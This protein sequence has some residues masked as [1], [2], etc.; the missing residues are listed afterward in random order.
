[1]KG[2]SCGGD[3]GVSRARKLVNGQSSGMATR[4]RKWKSERRQRKDNRIDVMR[5]WEC[6]IIAGAAAR[7]TPEIGKQDAAYLAAW[8]SACTSAIHFRDACIITKVP[9]VGLPIFAR[10]HLYMISYYCFSLPVNFLHIR[11][12]QFLSIF[13]HTSHRMTLTMYACNTFPAGRDAQCVRTRIG[14]HARI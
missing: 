11:V 14:G 7:K 1:M 9:I 10:V 4:Y 6:V 12:L 2:G 13:L 8:S 5:C 3:R